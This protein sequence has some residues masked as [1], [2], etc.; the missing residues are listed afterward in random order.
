MENGLSKTVTSVKAMESSVLPTHRRF[1]IKLAVPFF[2]RWSV[3]SVSLV[4]ALWVSIPGSQCLAQ[5]P[6]EVDGLRFKVPEDWPIEKRGGVL[7]PIPTEEYVSMKFKD[8]DKEFEDIKVGMADKISALQSNLDKMASELSKEIMNA[9]DQG[10]PPGDA[11]VDV[12]G[13]MARL[14]EVESQLGRLDRKLTNKLMDI[15]KEFEG[16][17]L[18]MTTLKKSL[19]SW[20][21]QLYKLDEEVGF[22]V[23]KQRSSD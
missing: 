17:N 21:T 11:G 1:A 5:N 7:A 10:A 19:E 14:D 20:Q 8:I 6:K 4:L 15:Q 18:H 9:Q 2:M 23:E 3:A 22:I 13:I 16:V 12:M